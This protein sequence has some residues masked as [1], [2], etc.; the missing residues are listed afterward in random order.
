MTARTAIYMV[1]RVSRNGLCWCQKIRD[2]LPKGLGVGGTSILCLGL[3][4]FRKWGIFSRFSKQF[5]PLST[6]PSPMKADPLATRGSLYNHFPLLFSVKVNTIKNI[7]HSHFFTSMKSKHRETLPRNKVPDLFKGKN[8]FLC[9]P[10]GSEGG[11]AFWAG[12]C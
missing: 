8:P 4:A 3:S 9:L 6:P 5:W 1:S 11:T 10:Q 12:K 7:L 2:S